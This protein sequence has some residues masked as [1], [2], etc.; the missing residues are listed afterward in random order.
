MTNVFTEWIYRTVRR[1]VC[2]EWSIKDW[3]ECQKE[4]VSIVV[5]K[6]RRGWNGLNMT[7][8]LSGGGRNMNGVGGDAETG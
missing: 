6:K 8:R 4:D 7:L 1:F 3:W 2:G 5:K